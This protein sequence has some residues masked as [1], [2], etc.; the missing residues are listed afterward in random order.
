MTKWETAN[1]MREVRELEE[2][3]A[4]V[5]LGRIAPVLTTRHALPVQITRVRHQLEASPWRTVSATREVRGV[6]G[7]V[8][9]ARP[10]RTALEVTIRPAQTVQVS[11]HRPRNRQIPLLVNVMP[12]THLRVDRVLLAWQMSTKRLLAI[13]VVRAA[14]KT[15]NQLRPRTILPIVSVTWALRVQM[16]DLA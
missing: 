13:M 14:L 2:P 16:A 1:A 5:R 12:V 9:S 4:S 7:P 11:V 6:E 10:G 15:R 3:V 8:W